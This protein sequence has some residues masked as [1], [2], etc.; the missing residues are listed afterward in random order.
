[1]AQPP[2]ITTSLAQATTKHTIVQQIALGGYSKGQLVTHDGMI[3]ISTINN[4]L[5]I[6]GNHDAWLI[7]G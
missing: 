4:N 7:Y 1:M 6:P 2:K 5:R 3:W